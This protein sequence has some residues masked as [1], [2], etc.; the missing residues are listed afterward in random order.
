MLALLFVEYSIILQIYKLPQKKINTIHGKRKGKN[1]KGAC[2]TQPPLPYLRLRQLLHTTNKNT[3][4]II[5]TKNV[6]CLNRV[7]KIVASVFT[8]LLVILHVCRSRYRVCVCPPTL[9]NLFLYSK[10]AVFYVL[11]F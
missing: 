4:T 2:I 7:V 9:P 3:I 10:Y 11:C 1:N 8:S 6:I 5:K